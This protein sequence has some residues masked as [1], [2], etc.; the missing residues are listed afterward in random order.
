MPA[1]IRQ[2]DA[3]DH[4]GKSRGTVIGA[5]S[6]ATLNGRKV[7]LMGDL[8]DC[9]KHGKKPIIATG[10]ATIDGK[11]VAVVGD[12]ASCGALLGTISRVASPDGF[13]D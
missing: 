2:G 11:K 7:A 12:K 8:Y 6:S 10:T 9:P 5:S 13:L 3:G 1:V 4:S